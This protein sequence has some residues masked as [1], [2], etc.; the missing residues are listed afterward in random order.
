MKKQLLWPLSAVILVCCT[1][2]PG[3]AD[4]TVVLTNGRR[5]TVSNYS[6]TGSAV[7]IQ[8]LGGVLS[9]PR[10]QIKAILKADESDPA[11][12][13]VSEMERQRQNARA[14]DAPVQPSPA[15]VEP[16]S[17]ILDQPGGD[18]DVEQQK[19]LA[20]IDEKLETARRRYFVA[21]QGGGN[22]GG[23]TKDGYRA[24]T[25]DLMSRLKSRRGAA[26]AE[27]EPQERELRDLRLEI[28]S[29]Q[30]QREELLRQMK[31]GQ[32]GAASP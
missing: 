20:E 29:L 3:W 15:A 13:N 12:L 11:D 22:G 16:V 28:E 6:E 14:S 27:Y 26:D 24:L 8:G 21:T 25:A 32:A 1:P 2:V 9:I 23:A 7:Q 5:I 4:Y 30:K 31:A 19:R 18:A 17:E 10:D